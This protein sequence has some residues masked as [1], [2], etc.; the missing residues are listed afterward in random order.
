MSYKE[1]TVPLRTHRLETQRGPPVVLQRVGGM[2]FQSRWKVKV[3]EDVYLPG[4][5]PKQN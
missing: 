5:H 3:P 4:A 2:R 1:V